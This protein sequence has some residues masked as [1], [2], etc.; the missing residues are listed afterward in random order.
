MDGSTGL[1]NP[2][3]PS[4][5]IMFQLS[6]VISSRNDFKEHRKASYAANEKGDEDTFH[7]KPGNGFTS[8]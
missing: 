1:L 7:G 8:L 3:Y 6:T 4:H 2:V 5:R